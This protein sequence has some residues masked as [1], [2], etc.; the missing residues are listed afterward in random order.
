MII[1]KTILFIIA[2]IL[3]FKAML[4]EDFEDMFFSMFAFVIAYGIEKI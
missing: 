2:V 3:L 4:E 1:V